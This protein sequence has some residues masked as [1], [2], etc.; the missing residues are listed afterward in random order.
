[1]QTFA[2]YVDLGRGDAEPDST[3]LLHKQTFPITAFLPLLFKGH[4]T[5]AS[6]A[7]T[8][9]TAE[10]LILALAG[11]P[12]RP[13]QAQGEFIFWSCISL[14]IL[15]LMVIQLLLVVYW[16]RKLPLLYRAPD[17]IA[18]VMAYVA[19]TGMARDFEGLSTMG[20]KE[21]DRTVKGWGKKYVY[22]WRREGAEGRV[23][24]V[25][26]DGR[27]KDLNVGGQELRRT[28]SF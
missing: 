9:F 3:V 8:G 19:G 13:G 24:W 17:T 25:V 16:R 21:R 14:F 18:S 26:D 10:F 4:Y 23:R 22:G 15:I 11:M 12:Y 28:G 7:F 2:P 27:A 5:A 1:M 6:V 20:T